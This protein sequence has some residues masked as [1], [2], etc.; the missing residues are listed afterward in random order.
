M[1]RAKSGSKR[2]VLRLVVLAVLT[3]TSPLLAARTA[4]SEPLHQRRRPEFVP[5]E[6]VVKFKSGGVQT[7]DLARKLSPEQLAHA[8]PLRHVRAVGLKVTAGDELMTA[9]QLTASP[10]V[11]YAEPNYIVRAAEIPNDPDFSLQWGMTAIDAPRAWDVSHGGSGVIVAVVDTGIDGTHPDLK[12]RVLAGYNFISGQP[13]S[14]GAN[15]D[16]NEHGT[17]V[18]GIVAAS[19][20]N[21]VGVAGVAGNASLQPVKVL[22]QNGAGTDAT[23]ADGIE[24]AADNGAKVINLSLGGPDHSSLLDDAVKYAQ[25]AGCLVV[26]AAGNSGNDAPFYPAASPNVMAVAATTSGGSLAYYSN[27]GSY[28]SV[29]APGDYIVSTLPGGG[30]GY[31]SGTSM[32]AP[33]V[34]GLAALAWAVCPHDSNDQVRQVIQNTATSL[35][36][37]QSVGSG[38]IDAGAAIGSYFSAPAGPVGIL[39][40]AGSSPAPA[41]VRVQ[42]SSACGSLNWSASFS[43]AVSW[44]TATPS[45]GTTAGATPISIQ[46]Q[47]AKGAL[48]YGQYTTQMV[49]TV[50]SNAHFTIP[51]TFS[52]VQQRRRIDLPLIDRNAAQ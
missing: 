43:P 8:R 33:H 11:E 50:G 3:L 34:S 20:N 30:Y 26:A 15:S 2:C 29:A 22:D 41:T 51:V 18:S 10:D 35:G 17:H 39:A 42:T 31:L 40:D 28:L 16:D 9:A 27:Y 1:N 45:A 12:G 23:V 25:A 24:Y 44:L 52:Y 6:V 49:L 37:G 4:R 46:L 5:G 48:G 36:S 7:S 32:A 14:A 21:G 47:A 38:L 13:L 19:T